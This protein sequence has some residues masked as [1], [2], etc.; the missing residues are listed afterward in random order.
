MSEP[1]C[2]EESVT[3]F[4]HLLALALR[5]IRKHK[6]APHD[7]ALEVTDGI[8]NRLDLLERHPTP[9]WPWL[10]TED[11]LA[12]RQM[13]EALVSHVMNPDL[14]EADDSS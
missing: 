13:A 2:P 8:L 4:L 12:I 3:A 14:S 6:E 11:K 5:N 9:V 10:T 1:N 7:L